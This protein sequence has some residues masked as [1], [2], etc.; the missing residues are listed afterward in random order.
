MRVFT[1]TIFAAWLMLAVACGGGGATQ[2]D[3]GASAGGAAPS[4][5]DVA[6]GAGD[7]VAAA[8]LRVGYASELDSA[9]IAGQ[10]GLRDLGSGE[11]VIASEDSAVIAGLLSGEFDVGNA[12]ML[13]AMLARKAGAPITV[14]YPE[15]MTYQYIMIAQPEIKTLDDLAGK[16][17]AYHS[18]GS[19]DE[20]LVRSLVRQHDPA[21]EAKIDW[22]V[23]PESPNRAAA[24]IGKKID[25]TALE[26][27][28]TLTVKEELEVTTLGGWDDVEGPSAAAIANSWVVSDQF[29][30][31][32]GPALAE[33]TSAVQS[34][35][36]QFYED[37]EA[38]M[39]LADELLPDDITEDRLSQTY[40]FFK[41][42]ELY[43]TG[44]GPALTQER[45]DELNEFFVSIEQIEEPSP[46]EM[47][48]FGVI[49]K[50]AS[51]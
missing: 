40:D 46:D 45:W 6:A 11:P 30:A 9:D 2:T 29:L 43:P 16:T 15:L 50:V 35:Y 49:E 27:G 34:G 48:A 39:T 12:D 3:G 18:P 41:E 22:R 20:I 10:L 42:V 14:L 5:G 19:E 25:A 23:V 8:D 24:L 26:F 4:E 21:L 17:V 37:K 47:I 7:G 44:D 33:F 32:N 31:E 51:E 36:D 28:D 38:W 1:A 13:A